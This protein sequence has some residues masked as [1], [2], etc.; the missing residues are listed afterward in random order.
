MAA[1]WVTKLFG[2][3]LGKADNII[4]EVVTSKEERMTL[5]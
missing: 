4:D 2:G 5:K 3:L 1:P